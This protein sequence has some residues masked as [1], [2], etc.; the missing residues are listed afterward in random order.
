MKTVRG[1]LVFNCIRI[2]AAYRKFSPS[3][4]SSGY[5][6]LPDAFKL[7][8][9]YTLALLK[10]PAFRES[11]D[12]SVDKRMF[13]IHKIRSMTVEAS[14]VYTYPRLFCL[15]AMLED[16]NPL[17]LAL[18]FFF[19]SNDKKPE[20]GFADASGAVKLPPMVRASSHWLKSDQV[21]MVDDG[22]SLLI[23]LSRS[24]DP[25]FIKDVFG[26]TAIENIDTSG[27]CLRVI[28]F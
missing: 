21:Y 3:S 26:V 17:C 11:V 1:I 7:Y 19:S 20:I 25:R 8:P 28:Y 4:T 24:C 22:I 23:W 12:V 16:V 10:S 15:T 5:L 6:V 27:V 13:Y 14:V 9:I 2:L 18:Y